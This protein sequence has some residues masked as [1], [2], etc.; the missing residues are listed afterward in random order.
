MRNLREQR[1]YESIQEYA[2]AYHLPVSYVYYTEIESGKKKIALETSKELCEALDVDF[3]SFFYHLLKDILPADIQDDFL[4]LV[5]L[6]KVTDPE[7]LTNKATKIKQAYQKNQLSRLNS[8]ISPMSDAADIFLANHLD[9]HALVASIYCVSCTSEPELEKVAK[10]IGITMPIGEIISKFKELGIIEVQE[11]N[12]R[13]IKRLYD[14]IVTKDQRALA[15]VVKYETD[16]AIEEMEQN[17]TG[18]ADEA[19]CFYGVLGLSKEKQEEF[20]AQLADLD[21]EFDSYDLQG[22]DREPQLMTAIV[23][24]ARQYM[25]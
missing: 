5:P 6:H 2:R 14:I 3:I 17:W 20:R 24:P 4:S 15:G 19:T 10:Q 22:S 25:L 7:D 18:S 8:A 11:G 23:S 13:L 21:A 9:L 12:P 1:G 16:Q